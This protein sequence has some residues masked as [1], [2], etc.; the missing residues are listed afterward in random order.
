MPMNEF[1]A[2]ILAW[3][4][5]ALVVFGITA[6]AIAVIAW[7]V[8]SARRSP[9][10]RA[11]ADELRAQAGTTLVRLDDAVD[12]LDLEVGL[13]GA[14][15]GGGAPASLRRARLTAQHV[16]DASFEEY[17][18]ISA[19]DATKVPGG[20]V[21]TLPTKFFFRPVIGATRDSA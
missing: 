4:I 3:V 13:S 7:A 12:E 2:G 5:P 1:V 16:R 10:A 6:I 17:R 18:V 11:A 8:R 14:R 9:R 15:Y 21:A 20:V 19:P